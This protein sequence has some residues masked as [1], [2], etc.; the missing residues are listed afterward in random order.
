MENKET[1]LLADYLDRLAD[2]IPN[3]LSRL[4]DAVSFALYRI[5]NVSQNWT[6]RPSIS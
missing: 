5:K 3:G 1:K 6:K 2:E 4:K